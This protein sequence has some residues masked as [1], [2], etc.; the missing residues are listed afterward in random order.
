MFKL[1][2]GKL[3]AINEVT[4]KQVA[5]IDLRQ[6]V[7]LVDLNQVASPKTLRA[8]DSDEGLGTRPRSWSLE[9]K[10]GDSILFQA[11]KDEDKAIW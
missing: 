3:V 6:A 10:D 4:K 8:R 5:S 9:F 11:D 2:G 7:T 1:I